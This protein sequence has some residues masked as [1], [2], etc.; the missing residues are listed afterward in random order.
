MCRHGTRFS[1]K[2]GRRTR[3]SDFSV[4]AAATSPDRELLSD[5]RKGQY[6]GFKQRLEEKGPHLPDFGP[7][8]WNET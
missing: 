2:G 5:L 8:E 3:N 4:R 7:V 6:E 1:K